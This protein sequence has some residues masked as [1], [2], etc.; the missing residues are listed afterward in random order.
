VVTRS[1]VSLCEVSIK[2]VIIVIRTDIGSSGF[3]E[4]VGVS[5]LDERLAVRERKM[6]S[7][8]SITD[9]ALDKISA[10]VKVAHAVT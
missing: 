10:V 4:G 6:H 5:L 1:R 2:V 7:P 8:A 9:D 3:V